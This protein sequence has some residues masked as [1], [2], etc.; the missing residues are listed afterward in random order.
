MTNI[1][2]DTNALIHCIKS[3]I[4]FYRIL[5]EKL[6]IVNFYMFNQSID[7]LDKIEINPKIK[8]LVKTI[9]KSDINI[10]KDYMINETYVDKIILEFTQQNNE[11]F[12]FTQDK[13]LLTKLKQQRIN[14]CFISKNK[15]III[16]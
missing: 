7:E 10:I 15:T 13:E 5:E 14:T 6:K 9:I 2:I 11:Y 8:K 16:K 3:K 4:N 1:I 12:V